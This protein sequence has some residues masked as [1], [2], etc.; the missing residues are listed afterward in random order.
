[1]DLFASMR[2]Y[3]AVVDGGSFAAAADKLEISGAM[4]S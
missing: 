2:M 4:V 1:M 3:V